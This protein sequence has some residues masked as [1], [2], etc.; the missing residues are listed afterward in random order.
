M[1]QHGRLLA[2]P[3]FFLPSFQICRR[4]VSQANVYQLIGGETL[5]A[6]R[7]SLKQMLIGMVGVAAVLALVSSAYQGSVVAFAIA[8]S[9]I[10]LPFLF[11]FYAVVYVL[12]ALVS[13]RHKQRHQLQP[14]EKP[15]P[16]TATDKD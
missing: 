15:G 10:T 9:L 6:P 14:L 2:K 5:L 7:I 8:A 3:T 12:M 11:L 4:T 13:L 16:A 1:V